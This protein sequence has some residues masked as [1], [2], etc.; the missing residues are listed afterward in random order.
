M[1]G[2]ILR[3]FPQDFDSHLAGSCPS[4]RRIV[5]PKLVDLDDIGA[6]YDERQ[7]HKRPD[8]TYDDADEK[9]RSP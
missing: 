7:G 2:S 4:P 6:H 3:A 1:L 5:V 8:W 9:T